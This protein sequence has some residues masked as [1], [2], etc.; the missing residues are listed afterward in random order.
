MVQ[1]DF[2]GS[3]CGDHKVGKAAGK[4]VFK[5]KNIW[6]P[7]YGGADCSRYFGTQAMLM[8]RDTLPS[9]VEHMETHKT[10]PMDHVQGSLPRGLTWRPQIARS[11]IQKFNKLPSFCSKTTGTS[12]ISGNGKMVFK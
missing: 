12:S 5:P 8:Q 4:R 6:M 3:Y 2:I 11:P 10:L 1:L 9:V 7:G